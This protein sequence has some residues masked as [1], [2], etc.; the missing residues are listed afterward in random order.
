MRGNQKFSNEE[1]YETDLGYQ[2]TLK[3]KTWQ[4]IC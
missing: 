4:A 2:I 1:K 3:P